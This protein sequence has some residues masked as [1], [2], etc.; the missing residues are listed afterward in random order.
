MSKSREC[1][2]SRCASREAKMRKSHMLMTNNTPAHMVSEGSPK[3]GNSVEP[4]TQN[5]ETDKVLV[6]NLHKHNSF[7][8]NFK[9]PNNNATDG[10]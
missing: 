9:P 10:N 1:S 6:E 4:L 2:R 3:N 8:P 7:L 5:V